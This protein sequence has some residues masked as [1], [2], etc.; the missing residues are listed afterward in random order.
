MAQ[1]CHAVARENVAPIRVHIWSTVP[2]L[3]NP[4]LNGYLKRHSRATQVAYGILATN[5]HSWALAD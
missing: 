3:F 5:R 2:S 1:V 4:N